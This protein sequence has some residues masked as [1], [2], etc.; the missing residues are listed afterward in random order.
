M[1]LQGGFRE[2]RSCTDQSFSLRQLM[3]TV[4]EKNRKRFVTVVDF[5]KAYNNVSRE[6]LWRILQD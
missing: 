2:G 1:E 4:I 5:E 3:E 6:K